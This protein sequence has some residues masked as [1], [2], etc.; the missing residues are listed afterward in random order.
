MPA[1]YG[2]T[3]TAS[4]INDLISYLMTVPAK[5]EAPPAKPTARRDG[6]E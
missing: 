2:S 6:D 1:N 4:E 3:L 5:T